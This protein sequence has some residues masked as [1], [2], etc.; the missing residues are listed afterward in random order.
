[1]TKLPTLSLPVVFQNKPYIIYEL[2]TCK[3]IRNFQPDERG[4]QVTA[5]PAIAFAVP[6]A[7]YI[8]FLKG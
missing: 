6:R 7:K 1:M 4:F 2:S 5:L 8:F 3:R